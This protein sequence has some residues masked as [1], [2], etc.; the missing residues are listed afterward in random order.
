LDK[1]IYQIKKNIGNDQDSKT[2]EHERSWDLK[3]WLRHLC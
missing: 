1:L 2:L 3:I